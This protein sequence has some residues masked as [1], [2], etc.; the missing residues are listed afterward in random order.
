M[1]REGGTQEPDTRPIGII[2]YNFHKIDMNGVIVE[3]TVKKPVFD[4]MRSLDGVSL[5]DALSPSEL[6]KYTF[7]LFRALTSGQPQWME[8]AVGGEVFFALA[9][10]NRDDGLFHV[11]EMPFGSWPI[12]EAKALLKSIVSERYENKQ[13]PQ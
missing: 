11:H 8:Y 4:W 12:C 7:T 6:Q 5:E 2:G 1:R 10:F 3:S 9:L 13:I